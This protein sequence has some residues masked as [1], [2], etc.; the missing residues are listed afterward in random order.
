MG[1]QI[2]GTIAEW[3]AAVV[4]KPKVSDWVTVDQAMISGFAD[5]TRD[6]NFLH[7]DPQG[8]Q[9][10]GMDRTIAHGFLTLSLMAPMRMEAGML[11][12]PGLRMAMNYGLDTVRFLAPVYAGDRIRGHFETLEIVEAGAGRYRETLRASVEI[13]GQ[14]RPALVATWLAMYM[15]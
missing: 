10:V 6:W 1:E 4:G 12:P 2:A 13:E 3:L 11:S 9:A 14:D 7:V 15:T 8:A 5:V